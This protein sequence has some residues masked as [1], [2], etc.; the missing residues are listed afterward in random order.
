MDSDEVEGSRIG[1][2][3]A[4]RGVLMSREFREI[5]RISCKFGTMMFIETLICTEM[6][7]SGVS[8]EYGV[9]IRLSEF[10]RD[11]EVTSE[12]AGYLDPDEVSEL[13]QAIECIQ[14]VAQTI[15]DENR[16]Y[17]EVSYRT[18]GTVR[19]GFYQRDNNQQVSLYVGGLP[20]FLLERQEKLLSLHLQLA[21]KH[22][23]DRGMPPYL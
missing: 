18:R 23:T 3:Q 12:S 2:F 4:R 16:D 5:G 1:Q 19:F 20:S 6:I 8:V 11:L 9:A 7:A 10:N 17:T 15:R 13:I 22:L 21:M 14:G